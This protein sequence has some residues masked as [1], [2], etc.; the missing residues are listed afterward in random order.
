ME[1]NNFNNYQ[2]SN[3]Q[4]SKMGTGIIIGLLLAAVIGLGAYFVSKE[5]LN[6]D[7]NGSSEGGSSV[8]TPTATPSNNKE[9]EKEL[10]IDSDLVKKLSRVVGAYKNDE[11]GNYGNYFYK[12]DKTI[13]S[14][15]SVKFKLSL[16]L[17]KADNSIFKQ[18]KTNFNPQAGNYGVAYISE[19][20][21]KAA[22]KDMFGVNNDYTRTNFESSNYESGCG[23]FSWSE[24]NNRYEKPRV[25][26]CGGASCWAV[27]SKISS[28]KQITTANE[29]KIEIYEKI[30]ISDGCEGSKYY[31]DYNKTN[32]LGTESISDTE[33][34]FKKYGDKA[35]TYKYTF[36]KDNSGIY[37]FTSVEKVK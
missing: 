23:E 4:E 27:Q 17:S 26:G 32:L 36:V 8:T 10:S 12:K 21:V 15:E 30:L 18:D 37:V 16:A 28:A 29:D 7:N 22:Y 20:D 6:K 13:L 19:N 2:Q 1:E 31:S 9:T 33:T 25:D 14:N 24:E 5:F 3:K 35:D 34:L 11:V